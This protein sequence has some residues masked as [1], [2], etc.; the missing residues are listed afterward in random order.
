MLFKEDQPRHGA[1]ITPA[2]SV[3]IGACGG[4]RGQGTQMLRGRLRA[5]TYTATLALEAPTLPEEEQRPAGEERPRGTHPNPAA[6]QPGT[7]TAS[8]PAGFWKLDPDSEASQQAP[9][10]TAAPRHTG[11]PSRPRSHGRRRDPRLQPARPASAKPDPRPAPSPAQAPLGTLLLGLAIP[12]APATKGPGGQTHGAGALQG[13]G[14]L[15]RPQR[16][17]PPTRPPPAAL[18]DRPAGAPIMG[19]GARKGAC[20]L[21]PGGERPQTRQQGPGSGRSWGHATKT[22]PPSPRPGAG[23]STRSHRAA[24]LTRAKRSRK[25][26]PHREST[27]ASCARA[28]GGGGGRG[29]HW[30]LWDEVVG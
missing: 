10:A 17:Q 11:Q 19:T 28:E 9:N 13:L 22:S 18:G 24:G 5:H 14:P 4:W 15:W 29:D 7:P 30:G 25:A 12:A 23:A 26:S 27:Q 2:V 21:V 6:R 16:V 8:A 20:C 3:R 1:I